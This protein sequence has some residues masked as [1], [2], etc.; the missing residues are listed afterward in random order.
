MDKPWIIAA[1]AAVILIAVIYNFLRNK[2]V[3][4]SGLKANA[5]VTRIEV[6]EDYASDFENSHDTKT[7]YVT[8]TN[9]AGEEV[10]AILGN[11]PLR[12]SVGTQLL[13]R[14]LPEKPGY[15]VCV[16]E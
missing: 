14:Y 8:Y 1:T 4:D 12:C 2:K 13:V 3:K 16:K 9:A 7:Y 6:Q 15:V 5:S 10:E 11:P